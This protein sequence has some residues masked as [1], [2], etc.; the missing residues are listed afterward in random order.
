MSIAM[1]D[2]PMI[3]L[4]STTAQAQKPLARQLREFAPVASEFLRFALPVEAQ[5]Y[6]MANARP[7]SR[8]APYGYYNR[9]T[10]TSVQIFLSREAQT[11]LYLVLLALKAPLS[12]DQHVAF[13]SGHLVVKTQKFAGNHLY[14]GGPAIVHLASTLRHELGE[15]RCTYAQEPDQPCSY[16]CPNGHA[17]FAHSQVDAFEI[18]KS[19][20]CH[21]C[22]AS[23]SSTSWQCSCSK[24]WHTCPV[25]FSACMFGN[26]ARTSTA[27]PKRGMKRPSVATVEASAKRLARFEPSVASRPCL[28]PTLAARFPNLVQREPCTGEQSSA[29]G[30]LSSS[31]QSPNPTQWPSCFFPAF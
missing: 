23:H 13:S 29:Q 21:T 10:D 25:H 15:H 16:Y 22:K 18:A 7:P 28:G 3:H 19:I 14:R 31:A 4:K 24:K 27:A 17:R 2:N 30:S 1:A 26:S 6:F 8:L 11:K 5:I 12:R 9:V 20:W